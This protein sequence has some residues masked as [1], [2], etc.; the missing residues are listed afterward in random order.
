MSFGVLVKDGAGQLTVSMQWET[1]RF[2]GYAVIS[3]AANESGAKSATIAGMLSSD[4]AVVTKITSVPFVDITNSGTT[5]TCTRW[6]QNLAEPMVIHISA[7]RK[8]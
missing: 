1:A 6:G 4:I 3:F 5:I 8:I 7:L 2:I